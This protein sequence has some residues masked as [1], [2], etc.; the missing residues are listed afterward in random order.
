MLRKGRDGFGRSAQ[1]PMRGHRTGDDVTSFD[2]WL[3]RELRRIHIAL[4]EPAPPDLI[5]LIKSHKKITR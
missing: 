3:D 1:A 4:S 5:D 2:R